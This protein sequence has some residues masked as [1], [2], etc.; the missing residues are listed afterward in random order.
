MS[1][2]CYKVTKT[3]LECNDYQI[4]INGEAVESNVA[5]VS[6]MPF[7][8]RWPGHQRDISQTELIQFVSGEAEGKVSYEIRP[9]M[10]YDHAKLKIR[11]YSLGIV[12]EI[13][14]EGVIRF[15]LD[16]PAYFTVEPYGRQNALHFFIDPIREYSPAPESKVIYF[17]AGEHDVGVIEMHSGETLFIDEGAVVYARIEA[18]D[19]E[20]ISIIGNGILDNSRNKEIILYEANVKNNDKAVMNARRFH[21]VHLKDCKNV[22][23]EGITIRDSLVYN[24][25]PVCCIGLTVRNVKIIGCWRYNSDGIDMHNCRGVRISDCFIRTYD[26]SICI[27]GFD[28]FQSK[29]PEETLRAAVYHGG[30]EYHTFTDAV[31][32][33]CVIWNDWGKALEIGAETM[34]EEIFDIHFSDCD[35]IHLTTSAIDCMN[36]DYADVHDLT[37]RNI[38]IEADDGVGAKVLQTEDDQVY[39]NPNPDYVPTAVIISVEQHHEYTTFKGKCGRN[40]RITI[41]DI[42]YYGKKPIFLF[43]GQDE[44]HMTEDVTVRRFKVNGEYLKDTADAD[45]QTPRFTSNIRLEN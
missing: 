22:L 34:A 6:A 40:R 18:T 1:F 38:R 31:I 30:G 37:Y 5:R 8:R 44:E 12:P 7:N 42:E 21:T 15:T 10:P 16:R 35:L 4:V 29:N 33:R 26:D 20:N 27:K 2:R 19:A 11:P 24:I 23:I 14:G 41:E 13:D 28:F 43:R 45:W 17:G 32:E 3:E 39:V 9:T 25:R 36:V